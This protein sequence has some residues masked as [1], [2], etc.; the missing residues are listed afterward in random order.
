MF[1]YLKRKT[2]FI[3]MLSFVFIAVAVILILS[4]EDLKTYCLLTIKNILD[5][6]PLYYGIIAISLLL[7]IY[8]SYFYVRAGKSK[9]LSLFRVFGPL[10][11]P[12]VNCLGYGLAITS[13][14]TLFKG[15]F[16]QVFFKTIYFAD[17]TFLD[18]STIMLACIPLLI[19]SV[20][21]LVNFFIA[22]FIKNDSENGITERIVQNLENNNP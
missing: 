9:D 10:L 18:I 16:N 7:G 15:I 22:V 20:G 11:D 19:W 17:L 8:Y 3:L 21:G 6:K 12:P 14:L 5:F 2:H 13:T 4:I 1:K